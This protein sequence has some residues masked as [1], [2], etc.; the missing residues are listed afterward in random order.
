MAKNK[1]NDS[2]EAQEA[3]KASGPPRLKTMYEDEVRKKLASEL[4]IENPMEQPRLV[5]I[6]LNVNVGRH[7]ENTKL[8]NNVRETVLGTLTTVS[9]QKPITIRA[10]KSVANFKLREGME[11]SMMVTLRRER[12]WYF[13]DRLINLR[14]RVS[15]TSAG[16]RTP[17]STRAG[18]TRWA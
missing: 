1:K 6:V 5:K 11:S 15:R 8:P 14:C 4:G 16:S 18:R 7:L 12:M 2:P 3:K 10:K 9:G 17:R 13:L